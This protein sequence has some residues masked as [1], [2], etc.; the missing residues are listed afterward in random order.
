M[1]HYLMFVFAAIMCGVSAVAQQLPEYEETG[2]LV[3]EIDD[4]TQSYHTT[5]NTVP[6]Q[7]GRYVHTASWRVLTPVKMGGISLGPEGVF[8]SLVAQPSVPPRYGEPSIKITFLLDEDTYEHVDTT[9]FEVIY[10]ADEASQRVEYQDD[11]GQLEIVSVMPDDD[12]VLN[13]QGKVS[14]TLVAAKQQGDAPKLRVPYHITFDVRTAAL[15]RQ[16]S[17]TY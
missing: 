12:D 11:G 15:P 10:I 7:P 16:G 4:V 9:P 14:G 5:S 13:I 1:K 17:N 2:T 6:G 8:I 3:A